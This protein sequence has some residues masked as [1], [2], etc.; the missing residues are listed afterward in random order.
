MLGKQASF[1]LAVAGISA[2]TPVGMNLLADRL[3]D[4]VPGLRTLNS[5]ATRQNG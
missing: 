5:Y 4:K 1:W 2:L 3:G